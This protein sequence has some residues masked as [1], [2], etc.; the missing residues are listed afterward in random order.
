[1]RYTRHELKQDKI[2]ATALETIQE[3]LEHRSGLIRIG[4]AVLVLALLASG[5]YW[6]MNSQSE[7]AADALGQAMVLFSAPVVPP[8]QAA[9]DSGPSFHSNR[10][11]LIA[12]KAVFYGISSKYGW[13]SSGQYAHYMAGIAEMQLGNSTVAESQLR[14]VSHSRRKEIAALAKYALAS[15]YLDEKRDKDARELL[16]SL[17]DK[18]TATVPKVKAQL[19]LADLYSSQNQPEKAKVIYDEIA[20]DNAK[21]SLGAMVQQFRK[22]AAK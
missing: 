9:P 22:P 14:D 7:A 3:L 21:N 1:V 15:I 11:R 5:A 6:Y 12:A 17:I 16:Q 19:A 20:K 2:A 10:E 18:P 13:S 8:G 4:V